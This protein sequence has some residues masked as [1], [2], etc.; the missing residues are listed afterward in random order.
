MPKFEIPNQNE[1]EKKANG[2]EKKEKDE[3]EELEDEID[4]YQRDRNSLE[5]KEVLIEK[6][7]KRALLLSREEFFRQVAKDKRDE[8]KEILA[9][10]PGY[11]SGFE[12]RP[13]LNIDAVPPDLLPYILEHETIETLEMYPSRRLQDKWENE[14]GGAHP[15]TNIDSDREATIAEYTLAKKDGKLNEQHNFL[16]NFLNKVEGIARLQEKKEGEPDWLEIIA[17]KRKMREEIFS[18]MQD[19]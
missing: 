13:I 7:R 14:K 17:D 3:I 4:K 9:D 16:M 1:I 15:Q 11:C 10:Y 18:S 5:L 2:N 8:P 19:K 12:V 6:I